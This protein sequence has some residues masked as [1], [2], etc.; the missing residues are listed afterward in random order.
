MLLSFRDF[1]MYI[2]YLKTV[3]N[4]LLVFYSNYSEF[5]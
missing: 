5:E 3:D 4:L 1:S 2:T